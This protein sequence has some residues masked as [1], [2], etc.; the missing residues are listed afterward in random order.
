LI[1]ICGPKTANDFLPLTLLMLRIFANYAND[2][3]AVDHLAFIAH[4]LY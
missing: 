1:S 3:L 2:P 4:F